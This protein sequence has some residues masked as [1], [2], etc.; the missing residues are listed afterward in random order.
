VPTRKRRSDSTHTNDLNELERLQFDAIRGT[1]ANPD[2]W[3]PEKQIAWKRAV[4][5]RFI[6]QQSP[7]GRDSL[8]DLPDQLSKRMLRASEQ[9]FSRYERLDRFAE[10]LDARQAIEESF[11]AMRHRLLMPPKVPYFLGTLDLR[12][13]EAK[14]RILRLPNDPIL[15]ELILFDAGIFS[16]LS[17]ISQAFCF[18]LGGDPFDSDRFLAS[19]ETASSDAQISALHAGHRSITICAR[20][21]QQYE[22][23]G[24]FS[25]PLDHPVGKDFHSVM[26]FLLY[27]PMLRFVFA[28]EY[29]HLAG[30]LHPSGQEI[31]PHEKEHNADLI[32][33]SLMCESSGRVRIP[34]YLSMWPVW[35]LF[36]GIRAL[37]LARST[38]PEQPSE[39]H[40][41]CTQ[42]MA[43]L[44]KGIVLRAQQ[45]AN[46]SESLA[47][48]Q[49]CNRLA[50]EWTSAMFDHARELRK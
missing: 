35:V 21:L 41:S 49:K 27:G 8:R 7:E 48:A 5:E 2:D 19:F 3:L 24:W 15:R 40:P 44:D 17:A 39:S 25:A 4:V 13:I 20:A 11:S 37:L 29:V 33:L 10:L 50:Y 47:K 1:G 34:L 46:R 26:E 30:H 12:N 43:F 28:H 6:A 23:G 36:A 22:Q 14:T 38:D 16:F 32:G 9:A 31:T 18:L 45:D 42:R